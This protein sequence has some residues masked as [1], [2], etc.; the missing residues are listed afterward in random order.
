[1]AAVTTEPDHSPYDDAQDTLMGMALEQARAA[2]ATQ[3]VPVGA[4]VVDGSGDVIGRGRNE[5][6]GVRDPL[7]HAEIVAI[8]DAAAHLGH[9]RLD[10]CTMVVTLE[11]CL[12]C[13][14]A[15]MQSRIGTLTFGAY[16]AKAGACGSAWDVVAE[17]PSPHKLR[18]T[19]GVRASE[20]AALLTEFFRVRRASRARGATPEG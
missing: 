10:D 18:V 13:I 8:R 16:D 9:Y 7:A 6:V 1:M 2:L 11:P 12:M 14:G 15:I 5:R 3:D 19:G 20:C 17:N 4:V